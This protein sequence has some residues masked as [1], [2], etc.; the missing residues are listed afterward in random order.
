MTHRTQLG[1]NAFQICMINLQTIGASV[2]V[3]KQRRAPEDALSE[4]QMG[5]AVQKPCSVFLSSSCAW[6]A[7]PASSLSS[8]A[9]SD[10]PCNALKS[11]PKASCTNQPMSSISS[12]QAKHRS[13]FD[14]S[15]AGT[16][17]SSI[18]VKSATDN[19]ARPARHSTTAAPVS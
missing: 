13:R 5:V 3:A 1:Y 11:A 15:T 7:P 14:S 6:L 16:S 9:G 8:A 19:I 4:L 10:A 18:N 17:L 12:A 2:H